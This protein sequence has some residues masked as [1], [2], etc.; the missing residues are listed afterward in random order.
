MMGGLIA[1]GYGGGAGLATTIIIIII[2]P[3]PEPRRP[4]WRRPTLVPLP[5]PCLPSNPPLNRL[6]VRQNGIYHI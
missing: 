5:Y 1:F 6:T 3:H 2:R 4:P